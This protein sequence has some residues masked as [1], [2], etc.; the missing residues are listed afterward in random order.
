MWAAFRLLFLLGGKFVAQQLK[1]ALVFLSS[2]VE[3]A[4]K[5][6]M[7]FCQNKITS[8]GHFSPASNNPW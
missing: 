6:N 8:F 5:E 1:H 4:N 7:Q 2:D 3:T